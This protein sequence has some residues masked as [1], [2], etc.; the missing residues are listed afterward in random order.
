M[1]R[2]F[3]DFINDL[4]YFFDKW[5]EFSGKGT[6]EECEKYKLL[7]KLDRS[8]MINQSAQ[9]EDTVK[10]AQTGVSQKT[11]LEFNPIVQDIELEQE[12]IEEEKKQNQ[13]NDLFNFAQKTN[14]E[15]GGEYEPEEKEEVEDEE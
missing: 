4:K 2:H 15:N 8:M 11:L 7:V 14:I 10:L 1:E 3:Q 13:E 5:Y 12:R 6:F 9:I